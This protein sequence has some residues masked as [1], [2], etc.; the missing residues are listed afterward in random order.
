L[1][2]YN[3]LSGRKEDFT[4]LDDNLVRIYLCG[5]TV[6]DNFHIGHARSAVNFDAV[7]RYLEYKGYRVKFV[8]N[9]T[10]V[11]DKIIERA[12]R[13]GVH[14][15][16][17]AERYISSFHREAAKLGLKEADVYPR[18]TEHI[19][20]II[21]LIKSLLSK[22]LAYRAGNDVFYSVRAFK[23]YGKLSKRNLDDMMEGA[24]VEPGEGKRDPLDFAL[25]KGAKPGEPRWDSPWGPG[26]PGWH[27]ECSAMSVKYL[28]QPF[29]IHGGGADLIFPHHENEI[30]QSE[31]ASGKMYVR[32]WMHNGLL[33]LDEEKMS[34]SLGNIITVGEFL[35]EHS[36]DVFR[37]F[38]LSKHYRSPIDYND[39][40]I[41]ESEGAVRRLRNALFNIRT[42]SGGADPGAVVGEDDLSPGELE[43]YRMVKETPSR[44]EAAM[45]DDF[46]TALAMGAVFELAR[47]ANAISR[48]PLS[49]SGRSVLALAGETI[50]GLLEVM[51][52]QMGRGELDVGADAGRILDILID[53][54]SRLR[55]KKDWELADH[56]RD[57]L[58]DLGITLE[59]RPDG[60]V[61]RIEDKAPS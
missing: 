22:G 48:S 54:R 10:D 37:H 53:I 29:D 14:Y 34:K 28:G 15:L 13:E 8:Y 38:V 17:L 20:D 60:T 40:V 32:F 24:R 47:K 4:P 11:D 9:F 2:I 42:A 3:T 7:R 52:F 12:N 23:G 25:W 39:R 19:G 16:K 6:Y 5:L 46:N 44:F 50:S 41:A 35:E 36:P 31:G 30:A 57:R 27:I 49:D 58:A 45:D 59:D 18:A 1:K 51:G 55:E 21:E 26:R 61:W 43:L 33:R 56:I